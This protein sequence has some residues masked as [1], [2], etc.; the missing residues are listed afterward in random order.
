MEN[1]HKRHQEL[2]LRRLIRILIEIMEE[3]ILEVE[4]SKKKS[5]KNQVTKVKLLMQKSKMMPIPMKITSRKSLQLLK[6]VMMMKL[7][8][9]ALP[10]TKKARWWMWIL[11]FLLLLQKMWMRTMLRVG[12]VKNSEI[13]SL[14]MSRYKNNL[15]LT[16][17]NKR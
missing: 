16:G 11:K 5:Q 8:M 9:R 4:K 6:K 12:Q 2:L 13:L 3:A 1:Q 17:S 15:W 10:L 14:R 7:S